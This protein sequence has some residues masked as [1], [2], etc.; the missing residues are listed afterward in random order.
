VIRYLKGEGRS[1]ST[2]TLYNYLR[3]CID[4]CLLHLVPRED[5]LGKRLLGFQEKIYLTDHG[6][7]QAIYGNNLRD[8]GQTLENIVYMELVRRGYDV[9]FGRV[10]TLEVDFSAFRDG[11]KLYVQVAYLLADDRTMER[12]FASLESIPDNY[13]KLVLSM[14]EIERSRNGI[15]HKNIRDFLL[16]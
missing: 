14:D 9:K 4:S 3:Y 1:L 5:L 6:I 12:E 16:E 10:G 15:I 13:P 2:E 7:R 11:E 8:I